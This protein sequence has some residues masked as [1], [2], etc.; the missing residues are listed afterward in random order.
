AGDEDE[1]D[2]RRQAG[3]VHGADQVGGED[4]RA[5]EDRDDEQVV[6]VALAD[7]LGELEIASGDGGGAEQ[8][9]DVLA[10]H[11]GHQFA[12]SWNATETVFTPLPGASSRLEKE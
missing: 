9:L 11:N 1:L 8:H 4:E 12:S 7:L 2:L 5:L 10:S 6:V 3:V